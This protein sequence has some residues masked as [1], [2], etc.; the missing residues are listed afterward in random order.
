[1]P[2][3]DQR[4]PYSSRP[5]PWIHLIWQAFQSAT[6][7]AGEDKFSIV[8]AYR[9]RIN[10]ALE[11]RM[12]LSISQVLIL[13]NSTVKA[14]LQNRMHSAA[15]LQIASSTWWPLVRVGLDVKVIVGCRK[16]LSL[17]RL[18]DVGEEVCKSVAHGFIGS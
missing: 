10:V 2:Q 12:M 13:I 1:M 3:N 18:S 9:Q 4:L 15:S 7:T 16:H 14:C 6:L 11:N 17:Q 8:P 5:G